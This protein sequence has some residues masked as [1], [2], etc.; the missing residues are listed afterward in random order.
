MIKKTII[1]IIF[2]FIFLIVPL[3]PVLIIRVD[4]TH[5]LI[6]LYS[7]VMVR[8]SYI[9][10]VEL[11]NVTE[12]YVIENGSFY[13]K[14]LIWPG[15]GAGLSSSINDINGSLSVIDGEYVLNNTNI[16]IG[17]RVMVNTTFMINA[18]IRVNN[19]EVNGKE[20]ELKI[21]KVSLLEFLKVS[22]EG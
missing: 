6:V 9:H 14:T 15:Y 2:I 12:I 16:N 7:P 22:L 8:I 20:I 13:L 4:N 3:V 18:T 1:L 17:D 21:S 5:M 11:L 19:R 10:S